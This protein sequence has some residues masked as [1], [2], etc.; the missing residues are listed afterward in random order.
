M[1]ALRIKNY[2]KQLGGVDD[3]R[4]EQFIARGVN[5][6]DPQKLVDVVDKIGLI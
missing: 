1:S 6:Q 4:V 3:E 2:I 5:S